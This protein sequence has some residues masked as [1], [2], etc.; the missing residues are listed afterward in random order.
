M[1]IQIKAD[2]RNYPLLFFSIIL[3]S[4]L[5]LLAFGIRKGAKVLECNKDLMFIISDHRRP[6]PGCSKA[7][8]RQPRLKVEQSATKRDT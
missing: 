7:D 4:I 6:A 2:S 1:T 5:N 8:S 3:F